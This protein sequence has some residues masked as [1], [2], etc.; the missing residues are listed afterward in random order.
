MQNAP[1]QWVD[2]GSLSAHAQG[3]EVEDVP[4]WAAIA[5]TA[6]TPAPA[7]ATKNP[8]QARG[9]WT[10]PETTVEIHCVQHRKFDEAAPVQ[11]TVELYLPEDATG[12]NRGKWNKPNFQRWL[13]RQVGKRRRSRVLAVRMPSLCRRTQTNAD[14]PRHTDA[15]S[16][17]RSCAELARQ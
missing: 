17:S 8:S 11:R 6:P 14:T 1:S 3:E 4:W 9:R 7:R 2:T 10:P 12:Y 16:H 15:Q 13:E 5:D